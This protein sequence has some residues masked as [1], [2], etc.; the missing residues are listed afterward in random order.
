M[1]SIEDYSNIINPQTKE[2]IPINSDLGRELLFSYVEEYKN[3]RN[4]LNSIRTVKQFNQKG[5]SDL[6]ENTK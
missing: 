3:R 2:K 6:K 1:S 5:G 4:M